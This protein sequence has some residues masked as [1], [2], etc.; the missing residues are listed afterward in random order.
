[1]LLSKQHLIIIDAASKDETRSNIHALY[2]EPSGRTV[3]TDGHILA[4]VAP[5]PGISETEFPSVEDAEDGA[6]ESPVLLNPH[7]V[8]AIVKAISKCPSMP[9]LENAKLGVNSKHATFTITDL[10]GVATVI[11]T[12]PVESEFPHWRQVVPTDE[13]SFSITVDAALLERLCKIVRSFHG[14]AACSKPVTLHFTDPQSPVRM[15]VRSSDY[16]ELTLV[17][18]PMRGTIRNKIEP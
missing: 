4:T 13:P 17:L 1:M 12:Q 8:R 6:P 9:I 18:M 14:N 5:R 15:D 7:A 3:A 2:V 10:S 11:R 16:G